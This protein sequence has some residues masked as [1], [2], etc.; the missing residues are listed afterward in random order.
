MDLCGS[1]E[2]RIPL[3]LAVSGIFLYNAYNLE[4]D[5]RTFASVSSAAQEDLP[6]AD[7]ANFVGHQAPD[8]VRAG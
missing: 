5:Y 7:I 8:P 4:A 1:L 2:R 3:A 6:I